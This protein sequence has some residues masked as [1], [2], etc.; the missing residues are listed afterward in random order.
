MGGSSNT[1]ARGEDRNSSF[2][3]VE[4]ETLLSLKAKRWLY[5]KY[6][7]YR[8]KPSQAPIAHVADRVYSCSC[9]S[10]QVGNGALYMGTALQLLL[11][12]VTR[13]ARQLT[14]YAKPQSAETPFLASCIPV[15]TP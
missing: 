2:I 9:C 12:V 4:Q 6:F 13:R 7:L 5:L 14:F 10:S 11:P 15:P 3:A 1:G 8:V